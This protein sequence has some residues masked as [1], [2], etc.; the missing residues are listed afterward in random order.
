MYDIIIRNG[1]IV[2]GTGS[3]G[4]RGDVAIEG[5]RIARI[6]THIDAPAVREIDAGGKMVCPGFIDPHVH[7]ETVMLHDGLFE[8]YLKEGVTTLINGNCG[9][10]VTPG[11]SRGIYEYHYKNGLITEEGRDKYTREQP[12]WTDF[13]GFC[14]VVRAKGVNLNVGFLLGHG[15]IRWAVMGGSKDR[16]PTPEEEEEIL[17]AIEEGMQQGALGI[18]TGLS[19]IPSRYADTDEIVKCAQVAAQYDGVYAT[20]ARYYIGIVESTEEAIEIGE[21]SGVRVQV[22]HLKP[23]SPE[24]YDKVLEARD[25][26]LEICIDTIPRSTGHCTRKDRLLQFVMAVSAELFDQGVEG[27]KAALQS[28]E[29]R[30]LVLKDAYI[31]GNDMEKV[32]IINTGDD[33]IEGK[34][35]AAIA[36]ERGYSEPKELLLDLLADDNDRYTFWLGGPS[37]EDFPWATHPK[38][39]R[40][41]PLVMVGSDIIF[42][43]PWDPGSWYELQRR[44]G[45]V[46]FLQ[47]Y[48]EAGVPVEEIVRRNTSMAATMFRLFDR[49]VLRP[50]MKADVAVI[51]LEAYSFPNPDEID[52]TDPLVNAEGVDTV[53]VNGKVALERGEVRPAYAGEVVLNSSTAGRG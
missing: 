20:H 11:H 49:G 34:S 40:D 26:G 4:F 35:I 42:G 12:E 22:S 23:T 36:A 13:T 39:I 47:S 53:L 14:D 45:F 10:S 46:H 3:P 37:R 38:S 52:Y 19:Y 21:R 5:D 18:S 6:A 9:H 2:D 8:V 17:G 1:F 24:S 15:T 51:D 25:R 44:G 29:G 16:P 43:E 30:A 28:P 41:N 50:G 27:V 32:L 48:R 7:E 33:A 31:F